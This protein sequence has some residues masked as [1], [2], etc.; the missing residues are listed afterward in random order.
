LALIL[1]KLI[2][3][4]SST[5][6][7]LARDFETDPDAGRVLELLNTGRLLPYLSGEHITELNQHA[8]QNTRLTRMNFLCSLRLVASFRSPDGQSILGSYGHLQRA[9]IR[10]LLEKPSLGLDQVIE[11]VKPV[12]CAGFC[13]GK[14]FVS[15]NRRPLGYL[16]Y[17]GAAADQTSHH[18]DV[19]SLNQTF[20]GTTLRKRIRKEHRYKLPASAELQKFHRFQVSWLLRRLQELSDPRSQSAG[21]LAEDLSRKAFELVTSFYQTTDS[22]R[23]NDFLERHFEIETDRLPS[24]ATFEDAAYEVLFRNQLRRWE[25][26][27]GY[28]SGF[29]YNRIHQNSLPTWIAWR[30]LDRVTRN[31]GPALGSNII[32]L[33]L[34]VFALYLDKVQVD[35]RIFDSAGRTV[36][37][38]PLLIDVQSRMFRTTGSNYRKLCAELEGAT[39]G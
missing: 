2:S 27:L 6:G 23:L 7:V 39:N 38:H 17:T 14:E 26:L 8:D 13:S 11:L 29:I 37:A 3:L 22:G 36:A 10:A 12:A 15:A 35:K 19:A 30:E 18:A 25:T 5:L 4:D 34:A 24:Q 28:S 33:A 21:Q 20:G 31:H 9:E 1:P 32:D 16:A